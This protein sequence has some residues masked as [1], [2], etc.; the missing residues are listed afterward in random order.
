MEGKKKKR[1][2]RRE[3]R[4]GERVQEG[5]QV[6]SLGDQLVGAIIPAETK[7]SEEND[8]YGWGHPAGDV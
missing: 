4:K 5:S 1:K 6:S 3:R 2:R 8:E 7:V